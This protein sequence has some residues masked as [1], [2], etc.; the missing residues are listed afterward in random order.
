[1]LQ[2]LSLAEKVRGG[3]F[4]PG[5]YFILSRY[6]VD[7]QEILMLEVRQSAQQQL[8]SVTNIPPIIGVNGR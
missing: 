8:F 4:I 2:M 7:R 1:M 3:S 5:R 6:F